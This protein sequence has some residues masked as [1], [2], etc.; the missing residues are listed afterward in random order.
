M[1]KTIGIIVL[2]VVG[3]L[4][5]GRTTAFYTD[6]AV[7]GASTFSAGTLDLGMTSSGS[8]F[9]LQ[10]ENM[11]PGE[12]TGQKE[13]T[14]TNDGTLDLQ[15]DELQVNNLNV[16]DSHSSCLNGVGFA[17]MMKV[18]VYKENSDGTMVTIL[19]SNLKEL[20]SG[21]EFESPLTLSED[22]SGTYFLEAIFSSEATSDMQGCLLDEVTFE[23]KA[24]QVTD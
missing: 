23:V 8:D 4:L 9:V 18:H 7:S 12:S 11:A 22:E 6:S 15:I 16:D 13:L 19:S 2:L 21:K 17:E 3:A 10:L 14:L 20:E 1:K 5:I 24:S